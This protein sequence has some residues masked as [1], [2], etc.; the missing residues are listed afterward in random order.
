MTELKEKDIIDLSIVIPCLNEADTLATCIQKAQKVIKEKCINAEI[1][2]ADN[3][4]SDGSQNIAKKLNATV[5]NVESS[6][7]GSAL[8][9]GIEASKGKYIIMGDADDSYDFL[10]IPKFVSKLID[11]NEL[12][13]GCRLPSGGGTI[14]PNAMPTLHRLI[15]NPLFSYLIRAWFNYPIHDVYCGLRGFTRKLYDHLELQCSGMEFATEMVIKSILFGAK[16]AE[17]PTTLY[18]DGRKSHKPHLKTFKDGWR[19]LKFFLLFSPKWLFLV[20]G[21]LLMFAG[22]LGFII[23]LPQISFNGITFDLH[24]LL[25]SSMFILCGHQS[26]SFAILAKTYS[27]NEGLRPK[28]SISTAFW[29][30]LT[31]ERAIV[32]S[33]LLMIIGSILLL[34]AFLQWKQTNFGHLNYIHT[35]RIV[36]PGVTFATLG[37]QTVIFRFLGSILFLRRRR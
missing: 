22:L 6:G 12:V 11:G 25:F 16:I 33:S 4:S 24:T 15:G 8:M 27:I 37:F 20:P 3:G 30:L 28:D 5:I 7:Y 35:M 23:A 36:I 26:I 2:I 32:C 9:G 19:T 29:N 31:L 21:L 10:E 13:I 14:M 1:I 18:P 34:E 17:I